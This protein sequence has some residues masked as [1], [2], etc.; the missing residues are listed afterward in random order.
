[1][2]LKAEKYGPEKATTLNTYAA[3]KSGLKNWDGSGSI[4]S[5]LSGKAKKRFVRSCLSSFH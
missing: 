2:V 1:M 3:M 5:T 4:S